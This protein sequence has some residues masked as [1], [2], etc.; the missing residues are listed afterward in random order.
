MSADNWD[1]CPKCLSEAVAAAEKAAAKVAA[2]YG[3]VPVEEFDRKR[4]AL[5]PV[6]SN[7]FRT[8]RE[9][10]EIGIDDGSVEVD[11]RGQCTACGL[12]AS[13]KERYPFWGQA[14]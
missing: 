2:L 14:S 11:Y 6:E 12:S 9:D 10:Y 5:E 3:K 13:V 1:V 8:F 4:A 7:D